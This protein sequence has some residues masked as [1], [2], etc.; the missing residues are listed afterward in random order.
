MHHLVKILS[1]TLSMA[2]SAL[3]VHA[4]RGWIVPSSTVLS[5]GEPAVTF[6]AAVSNGIFHLDHRPMGAD[7]ITALAPDGS[8]VALQN[9]HTG[10]LRSTFDL[11]LT[12]K[13]TY[14]VFS[15]SNGLMAT[16]E[17]NG[18]RKRWRGDAESFAEEVPTD[19][20]KLQVSETSRRIETFVTAG[21]PT[22]DVFKTK[23]QSGLTLVP[24]THPNDLYAG[25]QAS[26]TLLIDGKP[27][28]NAEVE[29]IQDGMRYRNQQDGI[30]VTTNEQGKFTV[31]WPAAGLYWLGASY[32]DDQSDFSFKG[33]H[34][35]RRAGYSATFEVLPL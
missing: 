24:Q 20:D 31:T 21:A 23:S 22:T 15:A 35:K 32:E 3:P 28:A 1:L 13:G 4:H 33:I 7:R 14:K 17:E 30:T 12:Q 16:W 8:E 25:E 9:A 18:E 29:I 5:A 19:A 2:A 26:F 27:A 34:A 10:L 6:D 11:Q